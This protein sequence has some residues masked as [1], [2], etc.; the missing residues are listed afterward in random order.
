MLI[1]SWADY[2]PG[3]ALITKPG[4][5]S[6]IAALDAANLLAETSKITV[7]DKRAARKA[8]AFIDGITNPDCMERRITRVHSYLSGELGEKHPAVRAIHALINKIRPRSKGV[9]STQV[10]IVPANGFIAIPNTL[11]GTSA[12]NIGNTNLSWHEEATGQPGET[13]APGQST[14][15]FAHDGTIVV[16]NLSSTTK[17][18]VSLP[19][20]TGKEVSRS[21]SEK[22]FASLTGHADEMIARINALGGPAAAGPAAAPA[23]PAPPAFSYNP[24]DPKLTI[25]QLTSLNN[26]LKLLNQQTAAALDAYGIANRNRKKLYDGTSGMEERTRLIRNYTASFPGGKKSEHFIE[27][28]QAIK[29]T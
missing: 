12:K 8:L 21:N 28:T 7:D 13:F 6:F 18:K 20:F 3:N 23:A 2:S 4:L 14:V 15:P 5:T 29:G 27:F 26:E 10:F 11:N 19:V 25:A 22:S 16:K 17:G 24:P 1:Q 9:T